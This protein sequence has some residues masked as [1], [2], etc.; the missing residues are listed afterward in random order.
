MEWRRFV[1]YLWNDPRMFVRFWTCICSTTS[2]V[3]S[4]QTFN[5]L[6][7][8]CMCCTSNPQQIKVSGVWE[9]DLEPSQQN[10][11]GNRWYSP[12]RSIPTACTLDTNV[13]QIQIRTNIWH[14]CEHDSL[15]HVCECCE[16]GPM[17]EASLFVFFIVLQP[18]QPT[19]TVHNVRMNTISFITYMQQAAQSKMS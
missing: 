12:T 16:V 11:F 10:T 6:Q 1:T 8:C 14:S 9:W 3:D 17:M 18:R 19:S 4:L 5:Q 7:T 2:R 15:L 13:G